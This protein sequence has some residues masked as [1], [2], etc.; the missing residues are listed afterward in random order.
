M[1]LTEIFKYKS[2]KI[3]NLLSKS[4]LFHLGYGLCHCVI[5]S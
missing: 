2:L 4:I 5:G 1:A 3:N